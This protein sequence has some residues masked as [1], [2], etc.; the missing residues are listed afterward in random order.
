MS[1]KV[2][3][4]VA[5][6]Q[7]ERLSKIF[8]VSNDPTLP[9]EVRCFTAA[10][11]ACENERWCQIHHAGSDLLGLTDLQGRSVLHVCVDEGKAEVIDNAYKEMTRQPCKQTSDDTN[12]QELELVDLLSNNQH[13]LLHRAAK[14]GQTE[15]FRVLLQHN[16]LKATNLKGRTP[17]HYAV[18]YQRTELLRLSTTHSFAGDLLSSKKLGFKLPPLLYAAYQGDRE[19]FELILNRPSTEWNLN[20]RIHAPNHKFL[21]G[22]NI[23]HVLIYFGQIQMLQHLFTQHF[24]KVQNMIEDKTSEGIT[25][26]MLAAQLGALADIS[27]LISKDA[28]L[29]NVDY[30]G[31]T[32]MH[33]AVLHFQ[34]QAIYLLHNRGAHIAIRDRNGELPI[35]LIKMQNSR[36]DS[37]RTLLLG[38]ENSENPQPNFSLEHPETIV[39]QGGGPKTAGH[40]K[41]MEV[42]EEKGWL[43]DMKRYVGS[44]AG[45][46][47]ATLFAMGYSAREVHH[48]A[49]STP[50]STFLDGPWTEERVCKFIDK[51]FLSLGGLFATGRAL[52]SFIKECSSGWGAVS[53]ILSL[54][55]NLVTTFKGG[56][57][58][59]VFRHWIDNEIYLQ[60]GIKE[61]TFGEYQEL[62]KKYPLKFKH[63]HVFA[64]KV[65][66]TEGPHH[67]PEIG[68]FNSEDLGPDQRW[69]HLIISSA[70]TASI[71][72]P[73]AFEAQIL[74]FKGRA[75]N[76]IER[77]IDPGLILNFPLGIFDKL[78]YVQPSVK[79]E[80]GERLIFNRRALGLSLHDPE[81]KEE[82]EIVTENMGFW[83]LLQGICRLYDRAEG[84][85]GKQATCNQHRVINISNQGIGLTEF[86]LD[87]NEGK[88][89]A[90]I[91]G[92]EKAARDFV[93]RQRADFDL[94]LSL[95]QSV[96]EAVVSQLPE[97]DLSIQPPT[98]EEGDL[99]RS[100]PKS[101]WFFRTAL[102]KTGCFVLKN[103]FVTPFL[104]EDVKNLAHFYWN[105][106]EDFFDKVNTDQRFA[107]FEYIRNR[108][109][110]HADQ[111]F[112][113]HESFFQSSEFSTH[114]LG[115]A[116][117][118]W[119]GSLVAYLIS[120]NIKVN[121][122]VT[123]HSGQKLPITHAI[124][125]YG[126][127]TPFSRFVEA[128]D[129]QGEN[130]PLDS[131][132]NTL[133]HALMR[134]RRQSNYENFRAN[135]YVQPLLNRS[136]LHGETPIMIASRLKRLFF[137]LDLLNMPGIDVTR[138]NPFTR[139]TLLRD[140][141]EISLQQTK[142]DLTLAS[143]K[144]VEKLD[145]DCT[146]QFR[147]D[148]HPTRVLER[149]VEVTRNQRSQGDQT[150][151]DLEILVECENQ[152]EDSIL[153]ISKDLD[154]L[155]MF[156]DIGIDLTKKER[157]Y[158]LLYLL[159][160]EGNT[161]LVNHFCTQL[162]AN[163]PDQFFE[164]L[165]AQIDSSAG[166]R[167]TALMIAAEKGHDQTVHALIEHGA[168]FR[169]A[170]DRKTPLDYAK[171]SVAPV[172][173]N[174]L[175]G[176]INRNLTGKE[177][178]EALQYCCGNNRF[179]DAL[180]LIRNKIVTSPIGNERNT[181]NQGC[182]LIILYC[183]MF[184]ES[185]KLTLVEL[186]VSSAHKDDV[187]QKDIH[188]NT[189]LILATSKNYK[190]IMRRLL[191]AYPQINVNDC[192]HEG[193]TPLHYAVA[194]FNHNRAS[195]CVS[196]LL[197]Y[198]NIDVN[199]RNSQGETPLH[200]TRSRT[201]AKS[202]ILKGANL[203][204]DRQ[205]K[206]PHILQSLKRRISA[207]A[208]EINNKLTVIQALCRPSEN[209][210]L[211]T[212]LKK[213]T[214]A[215]CKFKLLKKRI[216]NLMNLATKLGFTHQ[217]LS[218]V[219]DL[220]KY[221][222]EKFSIQ[223]ICHNLIL[224]E[225]AINSMPATVESYDE[226]LRKQQSNRAHFEEYQREL[227]ET[228]N[229]NQKL[230]LEEALRLLRK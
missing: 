49:T 212:K 225:L 32:A 71:S 72:I 217:Q 143:A 79:G 199:V 192:N 30:Q 95:S 123:D 46:I 15:V 172:I 12:N 88:G 56:C 75:G 93:E 52:Y 103:S 189:P 61:C 81:S 218:M 101:M 216:D 89:K 8:Q 77:W 25:P 40:P 122:E 157:G 163:F 64:L 118:D 19:T 204:R 131:E 222:C 121:V 1:F 94:F 211:D 127:H 60:T 3:T 16:S 100:M 144:M 155:R 70:V 159:A 190:M 214:E 17:F 125:R 166:C 141:A 150:R 90:L 161:E 191:D 197:G 10:L 223:E 59:D 47:Q 171:R 224:T 109:I 151:T 162:K 50:F 106:I 133:L 135:G 18:K 43:W 2:T 41:A 152:R 45:A 115:I 20:Y 119:E 146:Q 37:L 176:R 97:N 31:R 86:S 228:L 120:K 21:H 13:D 175:V 145:G 74:R 209:D 169:S 165:N 5:S 58:G 124:L 206:F 195:E 63:L 54:L 215:H 78:K 142:L 29:N 186:L 182:L 102:N 53:E 62:V 202:L 167:K 26:L 85:V 170:V 164:I 148:L 137:V 112:R 33:H 136:N 57:S 24:D 178:I 168:D 108:D 96:R 196:S 23:I 154:L 67:Q 140:L 130:A 116:F 153:F 227:I 205:G 198:Q 156:M 69:R 134:S 84:L 104:G 107:L 173:N 68:H 185:Q 179:A 111:V 114:L 207:Q 230:I 139:K 113:R 91:E 129:Y 221:L 98:E 7:L 28:N 149:L 187:H 66:P 92:A 226:I 35:D 87:F 99:A 220:N 177:K 219:T 6:H 48:K 160:K 110:A 193:N 36:S 158:T 188:G 194:N 208:F 174:A 117:A 4:S 51:N 11:Q 22:G 80:E 181:A 76:P 138:E 73:I 83:Q 213:Q 34:K 147:P 65:Y 9:L 126:F 39:F 200:F 38:L 27:L 105:S 184:T 128:P 183:V 180:N 201:L 229:E 132:E 55:G 42:L 82:P 44:S 14:K 203:V 210:S